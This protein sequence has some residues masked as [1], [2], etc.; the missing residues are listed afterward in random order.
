MPAPP[1][2]PVAM[3]PEH[4]RRRAPP[5]LPVRPIAPIQVSRAP[6]ALLL[7][8]R[9]PSRTPTQGIRADGRA[10]RRGGAVVRHGERRPVA[11]AMASR[12]WERCVLAVQWS[13]RLAGRARGWRWPPL[14]PPGRGRGGRGMVVLVD[15]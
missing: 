1:K 11:P 7:L 15:R 2:D 14:P 12:R 4:R 3:P 9:R 10:A 13:S 5:D 6:P 8:L